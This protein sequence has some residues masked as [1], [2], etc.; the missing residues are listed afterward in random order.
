MAPD[1]LDDRPDQADIRAAYARQARLRTYDPLLTLGLLG[2][3]SRT[4]RRVIAQLGLSAGARVLDIGCGT[5]LNFEA[6]EAAVGPGAEI[7]GLDATPEML[8]RAEA[9]LRRQGWRNVVLVEGDAAALPF[10]EQSFAAVLSTAALSGVPDWHRAVSEAWR[11]TMRGGCFAVMEPSVGR[12][13]WS[14]APLR[15]LFRWLYAWQPR[16]AD[17]GEAIRQLTQPVGMETALGGLWTIL[18]AEKT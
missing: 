7:V 8:E 15:P 12:V 1:L 9:R 11:V 13:P 6:L 3:G 2:S 10:D 16:R 17:I 18:W 4:R 14:L 5:G